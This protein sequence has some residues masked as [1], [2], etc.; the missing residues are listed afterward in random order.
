MTTL[1]AGS[2]ALIEVHGL[3]DDQVQEF[4]YR[5][6]QE[7][8]LGQQVQVPAPNWAIKITGRE[9][10]PGFVLGP[11]D[12]VDLVSQAFMI[13]ATIPE[14]AYPAPSDQD[15]VKELIS[16]WKQESIRFRQQASNATIQAN[17]LDQKVADLQDAAG[18]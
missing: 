7:V 2:L 18:L 3:P 6:S 4:T 8:H 13:K 10:L 15:K 9:N 16:L 14:P 1:P 12:D 5:L 11:E 17:Q